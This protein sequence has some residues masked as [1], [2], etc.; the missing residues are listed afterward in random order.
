MGDMKIAINACFGGFGL[1]REAISLLA[2]KRGRECYFFG[3]ARG[4]DGKLNIDRYEPDTSSLCFYAFDI[5]NPNEVLSYNKSRHE[6]TGE[7]KEAHNRLYDKHSLDT[8]PDDRTDPL[9]I[10]VIEEL[11]DAANGSCAKLKVIEIPDGIE[12]EIEEYDGNESVHE[13]HQSWS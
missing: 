4:K 7:E 6:M 3:N 11:G 8:S 10:E 9:L 1:S 12:Y 5:P 2:K 13:V